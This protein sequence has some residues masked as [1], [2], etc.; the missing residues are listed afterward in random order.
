MNKSDL[1]QKAAAIL[2]EEFEVDLSAITPDAI[3]I[4]TFQLDSL[5]LVDIVV[6]VE[7]NF[8]ITL[9]TQDFKGVVTVQDFIN[10]ISNKINE[11]K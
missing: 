9:T 3:L 2:A 1:M 5:D 7:Q 6:L 11:S 10:M 8:G 4:E